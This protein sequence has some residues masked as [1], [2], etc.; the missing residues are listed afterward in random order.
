MH[1]E[2]V[3]N[4]EVSILKGRGVLLV[5][6]PRNQ[7]TLAFL[8]NYAKGGPLDIQDDMEQKSS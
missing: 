8:G 1:S 5:S 3:P 6:A 4:R 2:T 7:G